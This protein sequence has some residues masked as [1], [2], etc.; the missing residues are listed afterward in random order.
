MEYPLIIQAI[1]A[2][3][4]H[5]QEVRRLL[6]VVP[7]SLPAA[8]KKQPETTTVDST[9]ALSLPAIEAA[10]MPAVTAVAVP[11]VS[12]ALPASTPL[13]RTMPVKAPR[14][15]ALP[16]KPAVPQIAAALTGQVSDRPVFVPAA[17]VRQEHER[18]QAAPNPAE[19]TMS[20]EALLLSVESL[21]KRWLADL[22]T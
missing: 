17:Q 11:A 18:R 12:E 10:E 20:E 14:A 3:L 19:N 15:R 9:P 5:L 8:K 21:T 16:V 4:E 2:Y 13:P 1:D 6:T 22:S 7:R